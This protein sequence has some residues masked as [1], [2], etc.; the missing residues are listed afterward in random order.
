MGARQRWHFVG[1][2]TRG[3]S[4]R[5]A[6]HSTWENHDVKVVPANPLIGAELSAVS[7]AQVRPAETI[8]RIDQLLERYGVLVFR[9]QRATPAQQ[10]VFI[11]AFGPLGRSPRTN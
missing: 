7:L 1:T 10:I 11:R 8:E 3:R 9:D 4:Q 2:M 5:N 6:N